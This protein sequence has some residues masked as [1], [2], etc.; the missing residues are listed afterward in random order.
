VN[1]KRGEIYLVDWS[2]GRGSEQTGIRPAL[3]IQ[4]DLGNK[5]SP[6]VIVATISTKGKKVYP[7]HVLIE[8]H[9]SGLP[10]I[11]IVKLEQIMT[12]DKGRLIKKIGFLGNKRMAEVEIAIYR[13]LGTRQS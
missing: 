13:S 6:T 7:F 8:P 2:P 10:E 11:S 4:N 5:L 1:I 12:I 3:I 9:E